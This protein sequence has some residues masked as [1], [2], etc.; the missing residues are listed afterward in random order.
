MAASIN[1]NILKTSK[2]NPKPSYTL[3]KQ[4]QEI[5]FL[6]SVESEIRWNPLIHRSVVVVR[7]PLPRKTQRIPTDL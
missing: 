3:T 7:T 1:L 6:K 2:H 4:D 5:S